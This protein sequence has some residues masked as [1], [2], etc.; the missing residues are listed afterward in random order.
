MTSPTTP[1]LSTI[2]R[3]LDEVEEY[4]SRLQTVRHKLSRLRRGSKDYLDLL[5]DLEVALD[6]L[7]SKAE[8]AHE[9]LEE[10]EQ[11]LTDTE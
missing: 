9:A 5:P 2:E 1:T 7:G 4:S 8:H 10:F 3:L 11:S 6:V